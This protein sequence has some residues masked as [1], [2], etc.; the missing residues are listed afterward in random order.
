MPNRVRD[1]QFIEKSRKC[2]QKSPLQRNRSKLPAIN[3]PR[4]SLCPA[5]VPSKDPRQGCPARVPSNP[6]PLVFLTS[7]SNLPGIRYLSLNSYLLPSGTEPIAEALQNWTISQH[8]FLQIRWSHCFHFHYSP[9]ARPV[10]GTG[11]RVF[12]WRIGGVVCVG[13]G[14]RLP[15]GCLSPAYE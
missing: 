4:Y 12:L 7:R 2:T 13:G 3:L 14:A 1:L 10:V 8:S 15:A 11:M 6:S 9:C 5:I